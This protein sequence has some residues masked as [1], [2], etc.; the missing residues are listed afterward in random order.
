METQLPLTPSKLSNVSV[1]RVVRAM[2]PERE[3]GGVPFSAV[4]P[5]C[6]YGA[7]GV[8]GSSVSIRRQIAMRVA[9]RV[10]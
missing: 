5:A 6:V 8:G 1:L 2:R 4:D 7:A 10:P 9:H 3:R